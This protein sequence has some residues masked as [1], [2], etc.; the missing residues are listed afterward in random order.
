MTWR[1][2][3][4]ARWRKSARSPR[5][6]PAAISTDDDT[7]FLA[8]V[9]LVRQ[10]VDVALGAREIRLE[11]Q[12]GR[13]D[14]FDDAVRELAVLETDSQLRR[15][16]KPEFR[17]NLL[18]DSLVAEDHEAALLGGDEEKHAAAQR[19]LRHPEAF[20]G[21]LCDVTNIAARRL[22][23]DVDTNLA[24][25]LALCRSDRRNDAR[26][27]EQGQELF[28]VHHPPPA[29]PPPKEL[30]PPPHEPPVLQPPPLL[31]PPKV[32]PPPPP[33]KNSGQ[34]PPQPPRRRP[35][36]SRGINTKITN[37]MKRLGKNMLAPQ[38][39]YE[40]H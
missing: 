1:S 29:P 31:P 17:R 10:L 16:L 15:D 34:Q 33:R 13:G 6:E 24:G 9:D 32:V 20:E 11:L 19:R 2:S 18:V 12:S 38:P 7:S 3:S 21:P 36:A 4:M 26:L 28:L 22:R 37:R 27:I 30:P 14:R 25:R 35:R 8:D 39:F 5:F 23:L 40:T